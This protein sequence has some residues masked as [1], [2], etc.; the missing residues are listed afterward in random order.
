MN[1]K[2][3]LL[4]CGIILLVGGGVTFL[5]FTTE[6]T[7]QR[8][9]ATK[10]MA[11]LVDV[12]E[13]ERGNF[14]PEIVSTGTVQP[15]RE[16]M[17]SPRVGGEV[18]S[19]AEAFVPGGFVMKGEPLLQIDPADYRNI[20][21]LRKS[22]LN[23]AMAD[24]QIEQGRQ[25]VAQEELDLV[26]EVLPEMDEGL[27]LR[28]PQLNTVQA[29]VDA[30]RAAVNQARLDLQRTQIDAPFDAHILSRNVNEGS[31]V[32]PGENLGRLVGLDEYWVVVT[33]P[34]SSLRWLSFPDSDNE[35]AS[36]VIIHNRKAWDENTFRTGHLFRKIGALEDQ[37][38]LARV[39]VS[40]PDPLAYYN[41]SLPALMINSFVEVRIMGDEITDVIRLNRDYLREDDKVWVM[42]DGELSIRDV[43]IVFKDFEY[44]YIRSGLKKGEKV[45]ATNISTVSEGI[46]LR[47]EESDTT[48]SMQ[49][50][51]N[52]SQPATR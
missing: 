2:K 39:L 43:E 38:R 29:R 15:S 1:T 35:K 49:N 30:A 7:A 25:D 5:I 10:E 46:P 9:G 11:I 37:T 51:E 3:T 34:L 14:Q 6:P 16:V 31:Q 41:D 48:S 27:V 18:I 36:E 45:V 50:Q 17:L 47:T 26:D 23:Q 13:V 42:K 28:E 33:V 22:D 52:E 8:A 12:V 20:L 40:V 24:L 21:K 32:A 4:I 44:A 19:R